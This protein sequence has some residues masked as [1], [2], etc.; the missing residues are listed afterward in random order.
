[1]SV[2][3]ERG[4]E[5]QAHQA[6]TGGRIHVPEIAEGLMEAGSALLQPLMISL[7]PW[8]VFFPPKNFPGLECS[9]REPEFSE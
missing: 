5:K 9:Y 3:P 2:I 1:M 6:D 8:P 4:R 7:S